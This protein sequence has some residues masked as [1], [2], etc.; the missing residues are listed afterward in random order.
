MYDICGCKQ[1]ILSINRAIDTRSH[2]GPIFGTGV[3]NVLQRM[4]MFTITLLVSKVDLYDIFGIRFIAVNTMNILRLTNVTLLLEWTP[5][6]ELAITKI[7]KGKKHLFL[8]KV[9]HAFSVEYEIILRC[10]Y[11][12]SSEYL[13]CTMF[14]YVIEFLLFLLYFFQKA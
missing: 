12:L 6:R 4:C 1:S 13:V 7:I 8:C 2:C 10:K 5:E 9:M 3:T 11:Y 14:S